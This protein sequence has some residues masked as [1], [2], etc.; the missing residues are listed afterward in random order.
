MPGRNLIA[1]LF[2]A[3]FV[4]TAKLCAPSIKARHQPVISKDF[5]VLEATIADIHAALK[6]K[7]LTCREL[8]N[9][10]LKRIEA[11]DKAGPHLNAVQTINPRAF[12]E[13][14]RLDQAL[15]SSGFL[16]PLHCIPVLVKD[17]IETIDMP[18]TYGSVLFKDFIPQREA[19]IVTKL[20]KA[21]ALILGKATMGEF[22]SGYLGSAF[23]IIRNAYDPRRAPS[24][25]SGGTSSGIAANFATVGIAEDSGGS[26]RGPAAVHSLVGLRPTVPLVSRY[27]MMPSLPTTDTLGPITRTV[28]DAAILMDVIAGYDP[29]DPMTAYAFGQIPES[30]TRLLHKEGLR[31]ARIGVIREPMDV[32]AEPASEDYK[33]FRVVTDKA[34]LDLKKLGAQVIDPVPIP[35]LKDRMVKIYGNNQFETEAATD[36]YLAQH[37]KAPVKTLREILIS[38]RVVP[39]R[40]AT[41]M[42]NVG[43]S[44]NE[45]AYLQLLLLREET[46]Q[47]TLALMADH[48]LDALVYATFDQAP[49]LLTD[50]VLTNPK[51]D[52]VGPGNNR[53]LS[54]ALGFPAITVPAGFT[55]ENLPVGLEFLGRPFAETT[56]FK[57]A[58]AYEQGTRNRKPPAS[59]PA[60]TGES[61][62]ALEE[63]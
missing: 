46:R 6:S 13:A 9:L 5:N 10:Y 2:L 3:V 28:R 38:G 44:T 15:R 39:A 52:L 59:T 18:T 14:D 29:N 23:G 27:G 37:A 51:T 36:S 54:P 21:G 60:L 26:I 20:K 16:G 49:P 40:A 43:R 25:S 58:Y 17:Q 56:L 4:T 63:K 1:I 30:Y 12:E 11:Y 24:G 41:L 22:A 7:R 50:D 32:K 33:R 47:L 42:K 31:G 57:L 8:V 35:E 55:V 19:T 45:T 34:I 62:S 53:R 61:S 48:R